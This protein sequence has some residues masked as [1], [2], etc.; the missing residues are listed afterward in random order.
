MSPSD[1]SEFFLLFL[2][3][4]DI[5]CS[6][7]LEFCFVKAFVSPC[8][9]CM[10]FIGLANFGITQVQSVARS[11]LKVFRL[12][13]LDT[14]GDGFAPSASIRRGVSCRALRREGVHVVFGNFEAVRGKKNGSSGYR[15]CFAWVG[16]GCD[17]CF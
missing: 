3:R 13:P 6:K 9:R 11:Q 8:V 10:G 7:Q 2:L 1:P 12:P 16:G 17:R 14:R 15:L 4:L 5:F